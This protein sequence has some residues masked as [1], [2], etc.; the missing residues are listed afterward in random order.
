ML[1]VNE[2]FGPTIQGEGP[3][4]GRPCFFL[5]LHHCPVQCPGCDTHYTWD[6]SEVGER[7]DLNTLTRWVEGWASQCKAGLVL[8]GGEPLLHWRNKEFTAWLAE[9]R[10]KFHWTAL[11]TSGYC[12]VRMNEVDVVQAA[13]FLSQ[14]DEVALSPKVTPCLHGKQTDDELLANVTEIIRLRTGLVGRVAKT[15]LH[16]KFVVKTREDVEKVRAVDTL[17]GWSHRGIPIYL[18][19]YGIE[20]EEVVSLM[21]NVLRWAALYGYF[22]T[23]RVHALLWGK[24]RGT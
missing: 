5:R 6:G 10:P 2:V 4:T 17:Y 12:G 20:R 24:K 21:D 22:T 15:G 11:E 3:Y 13:S 16:L 19:P 8:S 9:H 1:S 18:M 14:F 23:P 7:L